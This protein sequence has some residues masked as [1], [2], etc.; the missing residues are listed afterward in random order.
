[1]QPTRCQALGEL[2]SRAELRKYTTD[3]N[4]EFSNAVREILA[5]FDNGG[6]FFQK[7][8]NELASPDKGTRVD[9]AKGLGRMY[10]L[11]QH[12]QQVAGLLAKA[13]ADTDSTVALV[14][15]QGLARWGTSAQEPELI[16]AVSHSSPD[17][18]RFA[19]HALAALGTPQSLAALEDISDD[20][21]PRVA[22]AA[23]DA[24]AAIERRNAEAVANCNWQASRLRLAIGERRGAGATCRHRTSFVRCDPVEVLP[25]RIR[26]VCPKHTNTSL[27]RKRSTC[28]TFSARFLPTSLSH[29]ASSL[30][31]GAPIIIGKL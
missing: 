12:R 10:P 18:R 29:R 30:T 3:H 7:Y 22:L 27:K 24:A 15:A 26:L 4:A 21:D 14:A 8:L 13:L 16:A 1:M 5:E 20:S 6:P 25:L 11:A 2:T 19:A 17:V 9:G 31:R 28:Q 23:K